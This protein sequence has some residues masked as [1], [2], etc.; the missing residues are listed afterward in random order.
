MKRK[1]SN[2]SSKNVATSHTRN[3]VW[4]KFGTS[5]GKDLGRIIIELFDDLVPKTCENFR[6]LCTGEKGDGKSGQSLTYA[7]TILHRILP[8]F[9][10]CGGDI[11]RSDGT[12]GESIYGRTFDDENLTAIKHDKRGI[13]TMLNVGKDTNGSQFCITLAPSPH[14]DGVNQAFGVVVKGSKVL[15]ALETY[16]SK[17][18]KVSELVGIVE[19]GVVPKKFLTSRKNTS[20]QK[21]VAAKTATTTSKVVDEEMRSDT[22]TKK[23]KKQK[24]T[25]SLPRVF[26]DVEIGNKA[27][28]RIIMEL[29]SDVVPKTA[30]N[31]RCLCTGEKGRGKRG[32]SLHFLNS[33]F[34]RV[35][36]NFMLQGGDITRGNGTG[37]DSIYNGEFRDENFK[38]KHDKPGLLSM[39]NAGKNTNSSQFFIT[40]ATTPHLNG[41]HVVF[42]SVTTGMN[43]V[44]KIERYGSDSG[45]TKQRI[46]IVHC[47]EIDMDGKEMTGSGNASSKS[48]AATSSAATSSAAATSSTTT[49]RNKGN[50]PHVYF[51]MAVKGRPIGR[52]IMKLR[53]DVVPKTAENFRCLCTGERTS[54]LTGK[55]LTYKRSK[56]HR[57]IPNFMLQGGDFTRGNGTGGESIYGLKF[58]DENFKLKHDKPG[59][60]SMANSGRNT[61][62][63]QFFIT[64]ARTSHLN[65]K[66]VVFGQVVDGMKVVREIE[67]L[68]SQSGKVRSKVTVD[69]CGEL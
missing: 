34:H 66:H 42:G 48:S 67:R 60:L 69:D 14:L 55:K 45:K 53:S 46:K 58:R 25:P 18:G 5:D 15:K 50:L 11:T 19:A 39:A 9:A 22:N 33:I 6:S 31:F 13:V 7:N 37:G 35:I 47:G 36:P 44:R 52:I 54:G 24:T 26:F 27:A 61:N 21:E 51:D 12:G 23:K 40:T 65:G 17:T 43:V 32:K 20:Q 29:R 68:G 1:S 49:Q 56:F 38:L 62:G 4:M 59:L 63:S 41:K 16:G 64:T 57:V 28:G 8:G 2:S 10:V 3:R 30:E